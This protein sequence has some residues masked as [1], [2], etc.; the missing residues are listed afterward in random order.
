[1]G[2]ISIRLSDKDERMIK[3][4]ATA[5]HKSLA[6]YCRDKILAEN[7]NDEPLDRIT[8]ET[9]IEQLSSSLTSELKELRKMEYFLAKKSIWYGEANKNF[10]AEF[11]SEAF[12][13][14]RVVRTWNNSAEA[15][16]KEI[17]RL[18]NS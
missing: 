13:R 12:D 3:R 18:F 17:E 5:E 4:L 2:Q 8:I 6:E 1:M 9:K 16:S 10:T 14:D 11:F 15:A 7:E